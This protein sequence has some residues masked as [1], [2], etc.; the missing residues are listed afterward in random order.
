MPVPATDMPGCKAATELAELMVAEPSV[1]FPVKV[2]AVPLCAMSVPT[3][4]VESAFEWLSTTAPPWTTRRPEKPTE[5]SAPRNRAPCPVLMRAVV[6]PTPD[7]IVEPDCVIAPI[8]FREPAAAVAV[9]VVAR[10]T[11]APIVVG[12]AEPK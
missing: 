7:K 3:V 4:P 5:L 8:R 1:V 6:A 12:A 2:G 11:P 9:L 10:M